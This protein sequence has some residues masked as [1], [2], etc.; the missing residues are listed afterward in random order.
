MNNMDKKSN[1]DAKKLYETLRSDSIEMGTTAQSQFIQRV[2]KDCSIEEFCGFIEKGEMP[3]LALTDQ[4]MEL[5]KGA[6]RYGFKID[7]RSP[8]G[9]VEIY[10]ECYVE[11]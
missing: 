9:Y 5:I 10:I 7:Y 2:A 6:R 11:F 3:A 8:G 1:V 4:E